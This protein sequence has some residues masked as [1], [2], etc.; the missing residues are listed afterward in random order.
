MPENTRPAERAAAHT[1]PACGSHLVDLVD[2]V[3]VAPGTWEVTVRCPECEQLH[4]TSCSEEDLARL[5]HEL[6][7]AAAELEGELERFAGL[8]FQEDVARFV[9]A[10]EAGAILPMDFGSPR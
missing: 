8:R 7:T 3:E 10:L 5:E 4:T 6:S 9:T 2:G 1:C